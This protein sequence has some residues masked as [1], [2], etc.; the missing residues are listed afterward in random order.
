M[1]VHDSD[2]PGVYG[3]GVDV[4]N[5]EDYKYLGRQLKYLSV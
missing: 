1:G 2:I 3:F 4:G 5:T